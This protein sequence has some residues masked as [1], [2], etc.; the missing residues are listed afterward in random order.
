MQPFFRLSTLGLF[1]AFQYSIG[2]AY[3]SELSLRSLCEELFQYSI[4]DAYDIAEGLMAMYVFF[5]YSI[6][7]ARLDLWHCFF[8]VALLSILHWRCLL[9]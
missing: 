8:G 3:N 5:Q 6:G 1:S 4:G 7:D 9:R 2:D